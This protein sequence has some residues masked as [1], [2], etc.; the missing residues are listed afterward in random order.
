MLAFKVI[1]IIL[2]LVFLPGA[3][4]SASIAEDLKNLIEQ[5]K[6][7]DAYQL[8]Q[9]HPDLLGDPDF[10]FF[11]GLAAVE[12]GRLGEGVLA[13]ERYLLNVPGNDRARLELARA[14]FL[15][16]EDARS[17]D[18]FVSIREKNPPQQIL[19]TIDRYLDAIRVRQGRYETTSRFYLEGGFGR[20]SNVN[21]GVAS[22]SINLPTLGN[23]FVSSTGTRLSDKFL[24]LAAGG[25]VTKPVA[26]GVS[27]FFSGD[28]TLKNY[29]SE[30]AFNQTMANLS[31]GGT[32][33][34][35]E[36]IYRA[37][38]S[39]NRAIIENDNFRDVTGISADWIRQ[40]NQQQSVTTSVSYALLD[41]QGANS[42][43]NADVTGLGLG[44]RQV[45]S[46]EWQP[47]MTISGNYAQER[48]K[49]NR[50]DLGRDLY[51]GN[52]QINFSPAAE[53]GINLGYTLS[54]S[55]YGGADPL[56]LITRADDYQSLDVALIRLI[57]RNWSVRAE[58]LKIKNTSNIALYEFNKDVF[59]IKLRHEWK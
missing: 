11:Y 8:G 4:R 24:H 59:A 2:V 56:M 17:R 36:D 21:S 32:W 16:G 58:I 44:F 41:Y 40:L 28:A 52:A 47:V 31:G 10:D 25:V 23:V 37:A 57:D 6:L 27:V 14:Y 22:S 50:S 20:D 42:V 46:G 18:E 1:I 43:R 3:A 13:L 9:A 34:K 12:S 33:L 39:F 26:P 5:G 30:T 38:L 29:Q 45:F 55:R 19:L 49:E 48:N 15:L 54:K 7:S 51:G 35:E 53:W